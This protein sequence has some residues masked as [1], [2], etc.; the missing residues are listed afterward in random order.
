MACAAAISILI[1][2]IRMLGKMQ[3]PKWIGILELISAVLYLGSIAHESASCWQDG[4]NTSLL[5]LVLLIVAA[6][7]VHKGA[8]HGARSGAALLWF[9]A[10]GVLL[11]LLAGID[12]LTVPVTVSVK[13]SSFWAITPLFLLPVLGDH[14]IDKSNEKYM[15]SMMLL[16]CCAIAVTLWLNAEQIPVIAENA[17][18]E[19]SKGIT[20]FGAAERFESVSA[21]LL[22]AGWF[23]LFSYL[24]GAVYEITEGYKNGWG[25]WGIWGT[26][27]AAMLIMYNLPINMQIAGVLCVISW[28]LIP[29]LTQCLVG[30]KKSK[31]HGKTP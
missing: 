31:K 29:L 14:R 26:I 1:G 24:L 7:S 2:A 16:G 22:T 27:A 11:I 12:E 9:V 23:A 18:Y 30:F 13:Q 17:F 19:Y 21:C 3:T 10:P 25:R 20:L 4:I 6:F 28:G 15:K 5:P 8:I